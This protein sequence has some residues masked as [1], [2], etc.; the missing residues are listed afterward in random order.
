MF[1]YMRRWLIAGILTATPLAFTLYVT[2]A[3]IRFIDE[4]VALILP[5]FLT[6]QHYFDFPV[7]G[8]G[9]LIAIL[10]LIIIGAFTANII[11]RMFFALS[12]AILTHLPFISTVYGAVRQI[13]E[14][15]LASKS[16]AFREVVLVEY[17]RRDMWVI[18]FVTGT[19]KG[20]IQTHSKENFV[21]VF[22]PTT[23]NPTSGFLLF[24]DRKDVRPL[25]MGVEEAVKM[26]ISAGIVTPPVPQ[27]TSKPK[28]KR[29][30]K[31]PAKKT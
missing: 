10:G 20:E 5:D 27:K 2:W 28:A 8:Y 17:P 16:D 12:G 1:R 23:P 25:S 19:T 30:S 21:N 11:G 14:T 18:G 3:L 31:K 6:P 26:V 22:V 29:L 9:L 7:P 15:I 24:V 13:L 4:V